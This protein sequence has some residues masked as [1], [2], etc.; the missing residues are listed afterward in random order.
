MIVAF[1]VITEIGGATVLDKR[2]TATGTEPT[3]LATDK[4]LAIRMVPVA[5]A[6]N[7]QK[8]IRLVVV[9]LVC[10]IAC[11]TACFS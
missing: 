2:A 7:K 3:E 11:L 5:C 4:L 9:K 6:C 10:R 8:V 1:D